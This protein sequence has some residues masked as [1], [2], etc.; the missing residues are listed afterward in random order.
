MLH[1]VNQIPADKI[2]GYG[3]FVKGKLA[4][5]SDVE[6]F[7]WTAKQTYMALANALNACAELRIDATPIEGFEPA[8]YNEKLGLTEKGLNASVLLAVG[9]RHAEDTAQNNKKV[10]KPIDSVFVEV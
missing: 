1:E 2:S 4:E 8:A 3:E 5:K 7:H 6:M 9:Y 10:R